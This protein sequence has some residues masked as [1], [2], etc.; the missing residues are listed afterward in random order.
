MSSNDLSLY[1]LFMIVLDNI[2][3]YVTKKER[4]R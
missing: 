3:T 4:L 1:A 2:Y